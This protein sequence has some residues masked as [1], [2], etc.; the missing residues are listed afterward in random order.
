MSSDRINVSRRLW[1]SALADAIGW[2]ESLLAAQA[3]T[4]HENA[5]DKKRLTEYQREYA[6][7]TTGRRDDPIEAALSSARP[8]RLEDLPVSDHLV[9]PGD[10]PG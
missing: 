2:T 3:G 8:V 1:I 6:A 5:A 7:A 9:Y 10:S 4:Q